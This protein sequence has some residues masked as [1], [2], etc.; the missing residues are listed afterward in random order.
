[1]V[2]KVLV[3]ATVL[4]GGCTC[5][6][7][8]YSFPQPDPPED[9]VLAAPTSFGSW[10]SFDT[11]PEGERLTM[12]YYDRDRGAVGWAVGVPTGDTVT[13][14]HEKVDGYPDDRGLDVRDAGKYSS[15]RTAPNGTVWVAY[16]DAT[17]GGLR[18]AHRIAPGTWA[19]PETADGGTALPGVGHYASLA[20]DGQGLPVVAHCDNGNGAVRITRYDGTAWNTVQA[21]ASRPVDAFDE[22][23]NP[24]T[25][26]AG[27]AYTDVLVH[28]GEI[29]VAVYDTASTSLHLLRGSGDVFED[30]VVD[31]DGDVGSWPSLWT[32]GS[33]TWLAYHDV[34]REDLM[35]ASREGDGQWV[36][37]RVDDGELRGA[38]TA[39]IE[40]DG[41]PV[42]VYFDGMNNDQWLA[43]RTGGAWQTA[44]LGGVDGAVGFHNEVVLAG[45]R[46]WA[47]SYDFTSDSLFLQPL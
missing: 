18:V 8:E 39:L 14:L 45:G 26:P 28:D 29:L 44:Q 34:G 11:S 40:R 32:D 37:E 3:A 35:F 20:L 17:A 5:N 43:T 24:V 47:G 4:A 16:H 12:S 19:E 2:R 1:M 30:E 33:Q 15:Q 23:G 10:L 46:L 31:D 36:R 13:W 42:I 7:T 21:Y 41:E 25:R 27:V 9:P 22:L 6:G 38:D